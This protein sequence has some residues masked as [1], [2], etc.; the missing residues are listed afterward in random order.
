MRIVV[1]EVAV[2]LVLLPVLHFCPLSIILP[3][4]HIY[5]LSHCQHFVFIALDCLIS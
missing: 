4:L 5:S 2:G 1:N 3:M